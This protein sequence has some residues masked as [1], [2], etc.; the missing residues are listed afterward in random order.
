MKCTE[1]LVGERQTAV[2]DS[3]AVFA[4]TSEQHLGP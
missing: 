3:L 1:L 2:A 4:G